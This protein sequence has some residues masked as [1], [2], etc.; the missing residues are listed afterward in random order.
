MNAHTYNDCI[1]AIN[2]AAGRELTDDEMLD[3][4]GSLRK[5]KDYIKAQD[6]LATEKE[7]A[8]QAADQVAK[9]IKAAAFIE[10][11]NA[12]INLTKRVELLDWVNRNFGN[13]PA[14][15]LEAILVGVNRAKAG[16]RESV[17]SV[18][19]M[20]SS[21]YH[22]GLI[23]DLERSG[24]YKMYSSG[25][26]DREVSRALWAMG[27]PNE[28]E[29][30]ARLPPEAR[31]VAKAINKWQE[32]TRLQAN[33]AGAWIG[34]ETGYITRQSHDSLKIRNAGY[35]KWREQ[36][37][38]RF[39]IARMMASHEENTVDAM[40]RSI[41]ANLA[42]GN[43]TKLLPDADPSAF[44]G[45]GNI[46]K[47]VS[48]ERVI[49]FKDSDSWFDYNNEYGT[50]NLR[51]AV[52]AGLEQSANATGIMRVLGTNPEGMMQR[53][54][55]E[56]SQ[57]AKDSGKYELTETID[58]TKMTH[59]K[60]MAAVDGTMNR[61][62]H[63]MAARIS[64]NVRSWVTLSKL[65]GMVLS[66]LN[67]IAVYGSGAAY[68]GRGFFSGM[69]E[70]VT[71]LGRNLSRR[72]TRELASSLG[73]V[74][75]NMVGELGRVGTF[76][77]S[78]SMAH[79]MQTFMK[80]N[81]SQWWTDRMRTSAALGMS[82]HLALQAEKTFDQ[83]K[84]EFQRV[85][86]LYNI[87]ATMWDSIRA[88]AAKQVDGNL[89]LVPEDIADPVAADALR[90]Y[91][92]DQTGFLALEPD[93]KTRAYMLQGSQAGTFLGE[94]AR[95]MMQFKSFTGAYMQKIMGRELL[96]RGYEGDS[97][98]KALFAGNGEFQG[99]AQI[100]L[101][102]TLLGYA[103]MCLKDISKG[104]T[105]RDPTESPG[106]AADVFLAAM[107]QGGGA[108][109]FGD[110]LFG[111]A[112]RFG[113]G[114]IES[115]AGPVPS[116]AGRIIDLYHKAREGDDVAARA[117]NEAINNTPFLNLF[118]LRAALNYMVIYRLQE[119]M[120]PGYLRR[121]ERQVEKDNAQTF[122]LKPSEA[123]R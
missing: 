4:L 6:V 32:F 1:T 59:A 117:M 49:H 93:A 83:L 84:P 66:Q 68:Q 11:R 118:Y 86:S 30:L 79:A 52:A 16:A 57:A 7:A 123:V 120:N 14:E 99:L 8:L 33:E 36:A 23:A 100:I 105:P 42:S 103:S 70:A 45:P 114:T 64:A 73:V 13:K 35:M 54:R 109:I 97:L 115:L 112:S 113:S 111:S 34:K 15:G 27:Q 9:D 10:R 18:Q 82:N 60:F 50:G 5:R 2:S 108:G 3:L 47:K 17:A 92:T 29:L 37:L 94:G 80:L 28:A 67:D 98:T 119:G 89:Y 76:S 102:S 101:T 58:N 74:L 46:A 26:M 69:T 95:F 122:L 77:E 104:R 12:A 63:Q 78:G 51:E 56:L 19:K 110:F 44:K 107:L 38:L 40:L 25:A 20:L 121:M 106:Q 90:L 61:P 96:G 116:Q 43:H 48:H 41:Y 88:T 53:L 31:A 39:D 72:E 71:G 91:Y 22:S 62:G 75:D 87:D 85:L 81:L 24:L 55:D 21:Q 65:G